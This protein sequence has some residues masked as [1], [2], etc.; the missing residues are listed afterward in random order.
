MCCTRRGPR[1]CCTVHLFGDPNQLPSPEEN[2]KP[3]NWLECA[4]VLDMCP[5]VQELEYIESSARYDKELFDILQVLLKQGNV[6]HKFKKNNKNLKINIVATNALRKQITKQF[7]TEGEE[8]ET[9]FIYQQNKEVYKVC[10][11]TPVICTKNLKKLK[12]Y[13]AQTF[14][15]EAITDRFVCVNK[16]LLPKDKFCKS[17]LPNYATTV[18]RMQGATIKEEFNIWEA[19]KMDR[20]KLYTALSRATCAGNIH[21]SKVK[22]F[23]EIA[24]YHRESMEFKPTEN[25]FKNGKVYLIKLSE[26]R[27]YIGETIK[28]KEARLIEH[29]EDKEGPLRDHRD[30]IESIKVLAKCPS[31]SQKELMRYETYYIQEF[32]RR[33]HQ[34]LNKK[35]RFKLEKKEE[36]VVELETNNIILE[37]RFKIVDDKKNKRLRLQY[38]VDGKRKEIKR[39]YKVS[40]DE[41]PLDCGVTPIEQMEAERKKLMAKYC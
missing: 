6:N 13:N 40:P 21:L 11:G 22:E 23:Y 28:T 10:E 1:V 20:N 29:L 27:Y 8:M 26:N 33:G 32:Q 38:T 5:T 31:E 19:H 25:P 35:Q 41:D 2:T 24:E 7:C 15:V 18:N 4:S 14:E 30:D 3:Y 9:Q 39:R 37:K 16:V 34:L 17:F 12:F 36:D